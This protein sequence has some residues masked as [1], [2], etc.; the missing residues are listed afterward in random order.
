MTVSTRSFYFASD[1]EYS[2]STLLCLK[3]QTFEY[4]RGRAHSE[5]IANS[6]KARLPHLEL[7]AEE[8]KS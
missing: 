5:V 8:C 1:L 2:K 3:A 6:A 7:Q 4:F